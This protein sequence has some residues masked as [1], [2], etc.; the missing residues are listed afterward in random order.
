QSYRA[1][2]KQITS[3]RILGHGGVMPLTRPT[4]VALRPR[5]KHESRGLSGADSSQVR[6][7]LDL[8]NQST[9][10]RHVQVVTG[11]G[12]Q[13]RPRDRVQLRQVASFN[14]FLH[15]AADVAWQA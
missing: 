9:S 14:I 12:T 13:D 11:C 15:G 8:G 6:S 1:K 10:N 3:V 2:A 4:G 5:S 7:P